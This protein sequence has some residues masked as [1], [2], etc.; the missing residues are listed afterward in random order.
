[1]P[2]TQILVLNTMVQL[3]ESEISG[4]ITISRSG[5]RNIQDDELVYLTVAEN[6]EMLK[7]IKTTTK[8]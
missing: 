3:K 4:E 2:S 6:M 7:K 5:A 1:M 8:K